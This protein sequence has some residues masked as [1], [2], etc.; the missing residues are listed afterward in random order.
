MS[1][2]R[3]TPGVAGTGLPPKGEARDYP[4]PDWCRDYVDA[5]GFS[6]D[7]ARAAIDCEREL[8]AKHAAEEGEFEPDEDDVIAESELIGPFDLGVG[9]TVIALS[10]LGCVPY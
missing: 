6:L 9:S 4:G 5:R 1:R 8:L 3:S 10:A 2:S 7:D